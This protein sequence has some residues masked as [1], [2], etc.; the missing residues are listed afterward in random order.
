M[1]TAQPRTYMSKA[2][3]LSEQIR[4]EIQ[5]GK[6]PIGS[7]MP[8][9]MKLVKSYVVSRVTIRRALSM[10][11]DEGILL[12]MPHRGV[13]VQGLHAAGRGERVASTLGNQMA[14]AAL[15]SSQPDEGLARIQE[16]IESFARDNGMSFQLLS[17]DSI[18]D[19]SGD[20]FA[21]LEHVEEL[22]IDGVIILPYPGDPQLDTLRK[23]QEEKFPVVCVEKRTRDIQL[24]AVEPDN[25][26]GMYRAAQLLTSKY[27]RPVFYIGMNSDHKNDTDR[28]DG[29][30]RAMNDFGYEKDIQSH[31]YL[32]EMSSSDPAYW[33]T[34]RPWQ[35]GFEV[36]QRLFNEQNGPYSIVCL[37]DYMAWGVYRAA[38]ER[39]LEIGDDV[40]IIGF[41]D[42]EIS[43]L[44]SPPLTTVR[45]NLEE[46]GYQAARILRQCIVG[47]LRVPIQITL[48]VEIVERA[49]A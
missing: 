38:E 49:S 48:P 15:L 13:M 30:I 19:D 2:V 22:G 16:G 18:S 24:P 9:E 27:R 20:V 5:D 35:Q 41:D 39:G 31:T 8:T 7:L 32:H 40:Q 42:L 4:Q 45:Q 33:K 21:A 34:E 17:S 3:R 23:L 37:N 43:S 28:Y 47:D 6:Y 12:K 11:I 29:Y 36:A 26:T 25:K 1:N 10:L 46:K 14:I 44:L